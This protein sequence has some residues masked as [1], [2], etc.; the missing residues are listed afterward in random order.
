[1][2]IV[3]F[4]HEGVMHY[5]YAPAGQTINK[6]FYV[7]K[8]LHYAIRRKRLHFCQTGDWLLHHNNAPAQVSNLVQ[9]Y[10]SK[11][12]TQLH[13]PPYSPDIAL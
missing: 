9:Q 6:E 8:R 2:L 1:M 5:E 10:L 12:V 11:Y 7:L 13:Q 4:D 3:F